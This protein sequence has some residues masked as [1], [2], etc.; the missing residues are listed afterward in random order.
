MSA[1]E[2]HKEKRRAL[3]PID[4]LSSARGG[5]SLYRRRRLGYFVGLW[6]ENLCE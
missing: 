6:R 4:W 3:G 1:I 2:E 5:A